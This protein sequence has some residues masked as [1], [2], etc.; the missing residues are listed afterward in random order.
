MEEQVGIIDRLTVT[1]NVARLDL[2]NLERF[3]DYTRLYYEDKSF[4][5]AEELRYAGML[6]RVLHHYGVRRDDRVLVMLPNSPELTAAF[7]AIWTIGAAIIPV[8]PQWTAGEVAHIVRNAEPV[9]ALTI[10]AL[11]ERIEQAN[12]EIKTL[13]HLLVFGDSEVEGSVNIL[14]DLQSASPIESPADSLPSD[15]AVLLYTS[16]TT[17]T[18]KGVMLT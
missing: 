11:A 2:E 6:A 3:G 1:G 16:G 12:A 17:G 7:Q 15:L 10:P 4:T 9:V 13:K 5:N 8:I 18:P 14:G